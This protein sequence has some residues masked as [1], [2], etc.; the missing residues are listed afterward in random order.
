MN[1][2]LL[3]LWLGTSL[4][5]ALTT[6]CRNANNTCPCASG[7]NVASASGVAHTSRMT[8]PTSIQAA[9]VEVAV[10]PAAPAEPAKQPEG[11]KD[12][13]QQVGGLPQHETAPV[14]RTFTDLTA[15]PAF[16]H[17]PT[18][19]RLVGTLDYS[20]FHNSWT[21][22]FASVEEEDQYGGS[23]TLVE[24]GPMTSFQSGQLVRVEGFL[25]NPED[26]RPRPTYHVQSI[27]PMD[28]VETGS[29]P[30]R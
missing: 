2:S 5:A 16:A 11:D 30:S 19:R 9:P 29:F 23:V 28:R 25:V 1:R 8:T 4:L 21:L 14:R 13:I 17:D 15:N 27:R 22:R 6:G 20:H 10:V 18:Y 12:T 26:A 7:S 24:T 3:H